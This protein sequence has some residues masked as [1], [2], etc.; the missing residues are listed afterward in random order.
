MKI[1]PFHLLEKG[2]V[3]LDHSCDFDGLSHFRISLPL[4]YKLMLTIVFSIPSPSLSIA[5]FFF[6]LALW[7]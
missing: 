2:S 1:I 4:P 5:F 3:G 6:T 7:Y